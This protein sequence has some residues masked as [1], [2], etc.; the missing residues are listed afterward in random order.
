M[1]GAVILGNFGLIAHKGMEIGERTTVMVVM[2]LLAVGVNFT[3]SLCLLP[4]LGAWGVAYGMLAGNACYLA[5]T[6][7]LSQ[8]ILR[9]AEGAT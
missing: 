6:H 7:L 5:M 3:T 2:L 8:K 9:L 4:S 1:T